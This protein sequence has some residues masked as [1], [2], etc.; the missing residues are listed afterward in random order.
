MWIAY[1]WSHGKLDKPIKRIKRFRKEYGFMTAL[2][3]V[4][5]WV[6]T[7]SFGPDDVI[8][9]WIWT[10]IGTSSYLIILFSLTIYLIYRLKNVWS[11]FKK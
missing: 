10:E 4:V 8:A 3:I 1:R 7:P 5:W 9:V 2:L 11:L 6:M